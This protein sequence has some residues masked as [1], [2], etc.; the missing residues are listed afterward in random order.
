MGLDAFW[1]IAH[2]K[3]Y[4]N[5]FEHAHLVILVRPIPRAKVNHSDLFPSKVKPDVRRIDETTYEHRS[6]KRIFLYR[7]TQLDISSTMI[8]QLAKKGASLKYLVPYGVERFIKQRG[9]YRE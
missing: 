6:G 2:W 7:V 1:D 5:I 3:N 9:L 8:R 4:V